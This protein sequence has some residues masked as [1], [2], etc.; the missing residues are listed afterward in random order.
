MVE[1]GETLGPEEGQRLNKKVPVL[2]SEQ[3]KTA[4]RTTELQTLHVILEFKFL[5]CVHDDTIVN[6]VTYTPL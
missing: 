4:N 1:K 2:T 5:K 3:H 6:C